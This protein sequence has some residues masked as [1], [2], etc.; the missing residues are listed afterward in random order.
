LKEDA[1]IDVSNCAGDHVH[2][3]AVVRLEPESANASAGRSPGSCFQRAT[4]TLALAAFFV[5]S[6]CSSPSTAPEKAAGVTVTPKEVRVAVGGTTTLSATVRDAQGSEVPGAQVF[7]SSADTTL[8]VVSGSGVVQARRTGTVRIAASSAGSSD[9]ATIIV[10]PQGVS[11]IAITPPSAELSVGGTAQLSATVT[12]PNGERLEDRAV[13]WKSDK[14][15][16]ARV[17]A[18][19]RVT[20]VAPGAAVITATSEGRS[21]TAAVTVSA[22][23]VNSVAVSPPTASLKVGESTTLSATVRD[24][25]GNTLSGRAVVWSSSDLGIAAVGQDGLV[26]GVGAGS[27]TITATSEGRSGTAS[28]TVTAVASPPPPPPPPS[29]PTVAAVTISPSNPKVDEKNAITLTATCRDAGGNAIAG[30]PIGWSMT[31]TAPGIASF[32]VLNATQIRVQALKKGAAT[33]TAT[34]GGKTGSTTVTVK[35]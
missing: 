6:A 27:A 28:V 7:W 9:V 11:G 3:Q 33:F 17:D 18:N 24:A 29:A 22:V 25:S 14:E 19:G 1:V 15:S 23:A 5:V 32:S 8:A 2:R 35:D 30:L 16:V 34:C 13:S 21:T 20:G 4:R 10:S 12:G 31:A 26:R